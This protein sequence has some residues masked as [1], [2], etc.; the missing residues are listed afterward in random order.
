MKLTL[1]DLPAQD[2]QISE[3]NRRSDTRKMVSVNTLIVDKTGLVRG[4]VTNISRRGC[5]LSLPRPPSPAQHI[6]LKMC[7]DDALAIQINLGRVQWVKGKKAGIEFL[8]MPW[9][10]R[11]GLSRFCEEE[12]DFPSNPRS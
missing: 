11:L 9:Q 5:Q 7:P 8:S 12:V 4:Q 3:M 2:G 10:H 1:H 6:T